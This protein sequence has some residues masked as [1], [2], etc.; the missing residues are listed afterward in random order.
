MSWK[1]TR[2]IFWKI[3]WKFHPWLPKEFNSAEEPSKMAQDMVPES[4]NTQCPRVDVS[5]KGLPMVR[6][7]TSQV[8]EQI[9]HLSTDLVKLG[10][11]SLV[12][13]VF[14]SVLLCPYLFH[15]P[16]FPSEAMRS[17]SGLNL[18]VVNGWNPSWL[19]I[20]GRFVNFQMTK[21]TLL[22]I[23]PCQRGSVTNL[24]WFKCFMEMVMPKLFASSIKTVFEVVPFALHVSSCVTKNVFKFLWKGWDGNMYIYN[25]KIS[26]YIYIYL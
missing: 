17:M 5:F 4:Q 9:E 18:L 26:I 21:E 6:N 11:S 13:Y 20:R 12:R 3:Y 8:P 19:H 24:F 15:R 10:P 16:Q 1:N 14:C 22:E 25:I 7:F 23:N 2:V